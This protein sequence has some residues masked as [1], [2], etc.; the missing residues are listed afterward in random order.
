MRDYLIGIAVLDPEG[1]L[2][3]AGGRVVKNVAGYDLMKLHAGARGTLGLIVPLRSQLG[4]RAASDAQRPCQR[5]DARPRSR[6][7]LGS[8]LEA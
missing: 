5:E 4:A 7:N 6:R 1:N 3:R 2:V 8:R